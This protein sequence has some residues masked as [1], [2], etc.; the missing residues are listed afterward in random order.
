MRK[1]GPNSAEMWVEASMSRIW[2]FRFDQEVGGV[3]PPRL[4][5]G[6][7]QRDECLSLLLENRLSTMVTLTQR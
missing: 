2:V 6:Q 7:R 5:G 4:S 1:R 3:D